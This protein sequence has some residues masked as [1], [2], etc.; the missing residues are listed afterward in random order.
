LTAHPTSYADQVER[1]YEV[2]LKACRNS[3]I[4]ARSDKDMTADFRT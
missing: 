4:E 1:D 3:A 2:F